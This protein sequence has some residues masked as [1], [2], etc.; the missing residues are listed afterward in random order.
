VVVVATL[1]LAAL[2]SVVTAA[3]APPSNAD[4]ERAVVDAVNAARHKRGLQ[5]LTPDREVGDI[6]RRYSC[7]MA[8][9]KFF[10]HTAPNGETMRDR[11]KRG[12]KDYTAAGEN[13]AYSEGRD[14]AKKAVAGWMKS[15]P[16]R[17]NILSR[18]FTTTGVGVCRTGRATYVTQLFLRPR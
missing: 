14:P 16:H 5:A 2:L 3:A 17:E 11:L 10:D 6:A 12:G 13:I 15:P 7:E 18:D 9:G 8:K 4:T 1:V